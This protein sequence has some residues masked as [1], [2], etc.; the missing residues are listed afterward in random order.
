M[1]KPKMNVVE[2]ST[3]V[4]KRTLYPAQAMSLRALYALP[5]ADG[6]VELYRETT[7]R[8][9]WPTAPFSEAL[10][11]W[12]VRSGKDYLAAIIVIYEALLGGHEK[13][14]AEGETCVIAL[15]STDFRGTEVLYGYVK[16]ALEA[17]DAVAG[18]VQD[19]TKKELTLRNGVRIACFPADASALRGWSCPLAVMDEAAFL[20]PQGMANSADEIRIALRTRMAGFGGAAKLLVISSAYVERGLVWET[21]RDFYGVPDPDRLVVKGPTVLFNPAIAEAVETERRLLGGRD[22]RIF[23]REYLAE[24][25][26]LVEGFIP[27]REI[28]ERVVAGRTV[29]GP[30]L[31]YLHFAGLDTSSGGGDAFTLALVR[32]EP[33]RIVH[34]FSKSWAGTVARREIVR[35]CVAIMQAYGVRA[36][37]ADL[38]AKDW[39]R[40]AFDELGGIAI[41]HPGADRSGLYESLKAQLYRVDLLDL[42]DV[43]NQMARLERRVSPGGKSIVDHPR[44]AHDDEANALAAA[45]YRA[46][47]VLV[48]V[49]V[50]RAAEARQEREAAEEGVDQINEPQRWS[51]A[52]IADLLDE[53]DEKLASAVAA[54]VKE[55]S[56]GKPI[57]PERAVELRAWVG[58]SITGVGYSLQRA[59][60]VLA[61]LSPA[62]EAKGVD[63]YSD[64]MRRGYGD[65]WREKLG[66]PIPD[67]AGLRRVDAESAPPAEEE[68]TV[69]LFRDGTVGGTAD[70]IRKYQPTFLI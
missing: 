16:A 27:M 23:R 25:G 4:L 6:D 17:S 58:N 2:F 48:G 44:N 51:Q 69:I 31:R 40:E 47:Q 53:L 65:N 43:V 54:G 36:G 38:H 10:W 34:V 24:F 11:L 64:R 46:A 3:K 22:D 21:A 55:K 50:A 39:V 35:E 67:R 9:E 20:P 37:W 1:P 14:V 5:P 60:Q 41:Q 13:R 59:Q 68:T 63:M 30:D 33:G 42:P 56:T 28:L 49:A 32:I 61:T 8:R 45:A 19:K 70:A 57:T 52:Q 15:V 62:L 18:E 7:G 66:I 26:Q 29:L 12:G